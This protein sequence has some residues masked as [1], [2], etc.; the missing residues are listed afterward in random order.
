MTATLT[1]TPSEIED[2]AWNLG[3]DTIGD[4]E[5]E[6]DMGEEALDFRYDYSGRFMFGERCLG[7][8]GSIETIS[9]FLQ[10][11][12]FE[13]GRAAA[14]NMEDDPSLVL[15]NAMSL[16]GARQDSMGLSTI[17]YWP[18]VQLDG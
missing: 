12:A 11:L 17:M 8:V 14:L 9:R 16:R 15:Y 6:Y 3:F 4:D 10:Q 13:A 7:I 18:G 2:L 5:D 1:L